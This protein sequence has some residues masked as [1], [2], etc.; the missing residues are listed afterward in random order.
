MKRGDERRKEAAALFYFHR[1]RWR[2]ASLAAAAGFRPPTRPEP[3][4]KPPPPREANRGDAHQGLAML[5]SL[6]DTVF[7]ADSRFGSFL[8][9]V[10]SN[11]TASCE[12]VCGKLGVFPCAPPA[13]T[14]P[15]LIS[16]AARR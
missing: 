16:R 4:E 11:Y 8:R 10:A 13:F 2:R 12:V 15:A 7:S 9:S 1:L 6:V 5:E 14:S 3:Q